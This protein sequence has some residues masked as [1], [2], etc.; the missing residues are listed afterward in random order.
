[1][2]LPRIPEDVLAS[3]QEP[4]PLDLGP[5]RPAVEACADPPD[6]PLAALVD[7]G[8]LLLAANRVTNL[9]GARDWRTLI[10]CHLL[11]CALAAAFVPDDVRTVVDWGS[12]AGLPG[13]VWAALF[14]E[15]ELL[16]C[17]RNGKKAEFLT[18]AALRLELPNVEVLAG[19]AE[20]RLALEEDRPGLSVARAGEPRAE[21]LGR[22]RGNPVRLPAVVLLG[23]P[24][25][26]GGGG[27]A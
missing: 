9:T 17:E 10:E 4:N 26:G 13:L 5:L 20:E 1:M 24:A 15:K 6:A 14:P 18:E 22:L 27:P 21:L 23:G 11:D 7:Y 3:P 19:Q 2:P 25:V 16:L 8:K 12:G